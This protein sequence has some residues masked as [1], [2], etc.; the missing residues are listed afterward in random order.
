M[1]IPKPSI[2]GGSTASTEVACPA[3]EIG[4]ILF[5]PARLAAGEKFACLSCGARLSLGGEARTE[6]ASGLTKLESLAVQKGG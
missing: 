2:Q 3:C 1:M 5:V 6:Y 4:K